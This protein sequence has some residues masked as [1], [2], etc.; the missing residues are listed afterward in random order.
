MAINRLFSST[1]REIRPGELNEGR[2]ASYIFTTKKNIQR[3]IDNGEA[4][5]FT[6]VGAELYS[7]TKDQFKNVRELLLIIGPSGSGKDTILMNLMKNKNIKSNVHF[8][9]TVPQTYEVLKEYSEKN[10]I[11]VHSY[12]FNVEEQERLKRII[13]GYIKERK[14]LKNIKIEIN[15][16]EIKIFNQNKNKLEDITKECSDIIKES[17]ARVDRDGD[18][19]E[20]GIKELSSKGFEI[21][22]IDFT[23]DDI[24]QAT[25]KFL[26]KLKKDIKGFNIKNE[27]KKSRD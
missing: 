3:K 21:G 20:N 9:F 8:L 11:K 26:N 14:K 7:Y 17:K 22:R 18:I 19:F 27:T 12:Y 13:N 2:F 16:N 4:V 23:K 5:Q 6:E 15:D 25:K 1:S 24:K 10:N